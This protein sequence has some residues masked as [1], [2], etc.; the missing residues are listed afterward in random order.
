M[1]VIISVKGDDYKMNLKNELL[2]IG[3]Y[4]DLKR[5]KINGI[6]TTYII[7]DDGSVF[8]TKHGKLKKLKSV[9]QKNGYYLIHF[10]L[11]GKSYYRWLHRV[12]AECY[13]ENKENKPE[14]NHK[15]GN[16]SHNYVD[17]LEWVTS[18]EN[19]NHA[20]KTN[21]RGYG[22]KA[23]NT[24]LTTKQVKTICEMLEDNQL[25]MHEIADFIGCTYSM[26]FMIKSKKCW[27]QVS[28]KYNFDHY[29]KFSMNRGKNKLTEQDVYDICELIQ[30]NKYTCREIAKM[31]DVFENTIYRIKSKKCWKDI[32]KQFNFEK[33]HS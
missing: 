25:T 7:G 6:E 31:Y 12:V 2:K 26:V 10:H 13:L 4:D 18:K 8:N 3:F 20:F 32:T 5:Y 14:V 16:K 24:V 29:N 22:E 15:D 21:L 28:E 30:T 1:N 17:N 27:V 33:L 9:K 23:S 19:I 11:N